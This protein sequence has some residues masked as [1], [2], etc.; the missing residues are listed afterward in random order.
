MLYVPLRGDTLSFKKLLDR[1]LQN[2]QL[3][4]VGPVPYTTNGATRSSLHGMFVTLLCSC[5]TD[6]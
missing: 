5:C 2:L 3:L 1:L 6:W 4:A